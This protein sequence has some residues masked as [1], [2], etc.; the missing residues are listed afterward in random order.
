MSEQM[1]VALYLIEKGADYTK[2]ITPTVIEGEDVSVLYL[3][4]CSM[5]DLDSEQYK[6][7]MKVVAFLKAKGLDYDKEPIPEG[8]VEYMKNMYPDNWQE[9][10]KRY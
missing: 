5:I 10:V 9:Y 8:T 1:D 2:P 4:R 7:K 3:L 6:Y